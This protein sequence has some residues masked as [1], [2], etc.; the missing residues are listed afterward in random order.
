MSRIYILALSLLFFIPIDLNA[1]IQAPLGTGISWSQEQYDII[2]LSRGSQNSVI[3]DSVNYSISQIFSSLRENY[4]RYSEYND[5]IYVPT[6]R[7]DWAEMLRRRAEYQTE[8]YNKNQN[9]IN[10]ILD[11][12]KQDIELPKAAY[13]T[14]FHNTHKLY[15]LKT[16]DT[17]LLNE[18]LNILLPY[19][20]TKAKDNERLLLCYVMAGYCEF[21]ISRIDHDVERSKRSL[22]YYM[23]VIDMYET[24]AHFRSPVA[25]FFVLCAYCNAMISFTMRKDI[26][27]A[28]GYEIRKRMDVFYQKNRA[29]FD[30]IPNLRNYY[31]WISNLFDL[32]APIISI[33]QGNT[34]TVLFETLYKNYKQ[35]LQTIPRKTFHE[36]MNLNYS[37]ML[38]DQWFIKST[39][40]EVDANKAFLD[41]YERITSNLKG[42]E[43]IDFTRRDRDIQYFYNT[44][45]TSIGIL[46]LTDFS[47]REKH[48][49]LIDYLQLLSKYLSL[50]PRSTRIS[51]RSD[52]ERHIMTHPCVKRYL[53][54]EEQIRYLKE[55][56]VNEQP[57]TFAHVTMVSNFCD[58]LLAAVIDHKP[59]LL[60]DVPGCSTRIE[61]WK[62]EKEL[63]ELMH[64][65]A[66]F[67]DLGKCIIPFV[68]NNSFRRLTDTEFQL[69]RKHP[70][71]AV[72]FLRLNPVLEEYQD[73]ALGHHKWYNG[74][75]G[76]PDTFDN[77]SSPYK[78][79]IDI[80]TLC[81]CTDTAT[82]NFGR[83]YIDTK[84]FR[85]VLEEFDKDAGVRYN[86]NLVQLIHDQP[87]LYNKLTEIVDNQRME[88]YYDIYRQYFR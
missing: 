5:S 56:M 72:T 77:L 38:I 86:P 29:N 49:Y 16:E 19:Y 43:V 23:K 37:D 88:A 74:K 78:I 58:V 41:S 2:F 28:E 1:Q 26:S 62:H 70:E 64:N 80:L 85:Q 44:V 21:A 87:S 45:A 22:G 42:E 60:K 52:I 31:V 82:D 50:H 54:T 32:K 71:F 51:L 68:V 35:C 17:F 40:G 36:F 39:L 20:E 13:D 55:I 11:Y 9:Y 34:D 48:D 46:E 27:I 73:L 61:V 24:K 12:F 79:L 4:K 83:N 7:Y 6:F 10:T 84:K 25:P 18:F 75:G 14:L 30:K 63:K 3:E 15:R 76:Y 67:H 59:D 33:L 65:G 66:I 47:E 69:I 81:D 8:M 57:Q 53:T